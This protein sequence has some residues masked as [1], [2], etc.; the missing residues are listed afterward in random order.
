MK[1]TN[2]QQPQQRKKKQQQQTGNWD[3]RKGPSNIKMDIQISKL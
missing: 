2:K 3:R 1:Q